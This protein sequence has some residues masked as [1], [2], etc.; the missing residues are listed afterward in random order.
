ML[1]PLIKACWQIEE[2]AADIYRILAANGALPVRLRQA[3]TTLARDE[4]AHA[5]QLEQALKLR[6][7]KPLAVKRIAWEKVDEALQLAKQLRGSLSDSRTAEESLQLAIQL[8]KHFVK[9]HL[10]NALF[11]NDA[12]VASLFR[13]LARGDE[14][15][16][17]TLTDCLRWWQQEGRPRSG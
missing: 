3:F 6:I 17:Q 10:E 16:L 9:V 14:E 7:D 12:R 11:F 2:T 5:E 1:E 13:G 4:R 15:H 8:E